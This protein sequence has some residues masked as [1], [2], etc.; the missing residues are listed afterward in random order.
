[1]ASHLQAI[2]LSPLA[3]QLAPDAASRGVSE[4]TLNPKP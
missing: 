1:L 2:R 4:V 3:T